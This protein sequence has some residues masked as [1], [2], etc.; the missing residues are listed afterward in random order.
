MKPY[1]SIVIPFRNDNYSPNATEK[2]NI[3]LQILINQLDEIKIETEIIIIDWSSPDPEKPLTDEIVISGG[4]YVTLLSYEV[5]NDIHSRYRG[6]KKRNLVGEAAFNAGIRRSRGHFIVGKVSDT[7][8]SK[9][10]IPISFALFFSSSVSN[11]NLPWKPQ[12]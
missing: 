8:L 9:S 7:F 3:G 4:K 5:S 10:L 1:L 12:P 2:L 11:I 6:H